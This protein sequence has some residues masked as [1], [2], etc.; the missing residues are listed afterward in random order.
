MIDGPIQPGG[1][2]EG[3]GRVLREL[4]RTPGF[5]KAVR[6]LI[7][8]LDPENTALLVRTLM[9]EDPE[10]FLGLMGG[11]PSVANTMVEGSL[12]LTRQ[13]STFPPPL[14]AGF[15]AGIVERLDGESLGEMIGTTLATY[16]RLSELGDESLAEASADLHRGISRGLAR[17]LSGDE[18]VESTADVLLERLLPLA[19]SRVSRMGEEAKREGSDTARLVKG[20]AQGMKDIARDNPEFMEGVVAPL[21]EAWRASL[22]GSDGGNDPGEVAP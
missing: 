18:Q 3:A 13:L 19:A 12:E 5:K 11:A 1:P 20:L 14:L 7:T 6:T 15:L 8:E 16:I 10:F 22:A 21:A 4:L 17:S 2:I 9:W